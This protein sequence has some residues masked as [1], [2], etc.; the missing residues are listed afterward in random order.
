MRIPARVLVAVICV[1]A[2][3]CIDDHK[4]PQSPQPEYSEQEDYANT[5]TTGPGSESSSGYY[6]VGNTESQTPQHQPATP[7][8]GG[9]QPY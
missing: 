3:G 2:T 8:Q 6:G 4:P 9:H 1:A 7:S 5:L